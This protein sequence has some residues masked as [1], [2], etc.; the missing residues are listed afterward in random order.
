MK[1]TQLLVTYQGESRFNR[2]QTRFHTRKNAL[3]NPL[4]KNSS[5]WGLFF[6]CFS[7]SFSGDF[8]VIFDLVRVGGF[9]P[10]ADARSPRFLN[11]DLPRISHKALEPPSPALLSLLLEVLLSMSVCVSRLPRLALFDSLRFL[12]HWRARYDYLRGCCL[13]YGLPI[14]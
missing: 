8:W 7:G 6:G 11:P 3:Q 1:C 5:F 4:K 2:P 14:D 10:L 13:L 9:A 12:L